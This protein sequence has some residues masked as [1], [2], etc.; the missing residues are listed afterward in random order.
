MP[1]HYSH[2]YLSLSPSLSLPLSACLQSAWSCCL[3]AVDDTDLLDCYHKPI[4]LSITQERG[5]KEVRPKKPGVSISTYIE[6]YSY[7]VCLLYE[8]IPAFVDLSPF[9]K[10]LI[11][12]RYNFA[13][14][15]FTVKYFEG[16]FLGKST[17]F[18]SFTQAHHILV[19][20]RTVLPGSTHSYI[21][22][23]VRVSKRSCQ[24]SLSLAAPFLFFRCL[25]HS[26]V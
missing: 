17:S 9:S 4:Y 14:I 19:D 11:S 1:C 23:Y 7:R 24:L 13:G 21:M 22:C 20:V 12:G 16:D 5:R 8:I 3:S 10:C 6:R 15:Y 25:I 26:S 2:I 18:P